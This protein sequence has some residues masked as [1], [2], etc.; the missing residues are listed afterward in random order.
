MAVVGVAMEDWGGMLRSRSRSLT[1]L[2]GGQGVHCI[3]W[4]G[5]NA[6]AIDGDDVKGDNDGFEGA[7]EAGGGGSTYEKKAEED[8]RLGSSEMGGRG[9]GGKRRKGQRRRGRRRRR[10]KGGVCSQGHQETPPALT[11]AEGCGLGE[12]W[13]SV[14]VRCYLFNAIISLVIIIL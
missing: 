12:W 3:V 8:G 9:G 2:M 7:G 11:K 1:R 14:S 13:Y 10:K 6:V 4:Q 5:G